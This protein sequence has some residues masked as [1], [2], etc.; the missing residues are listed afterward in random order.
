MYIYIEKISIAKKTA[1]VR[2][3]IGTR[4]RERR[5]KCIF[6]GTFSD[7]KDDDAAKTTELNQHKPAKLWFCSDIVWTDD[8]EETRNKTHHLLSGAFGLDKC[9]VVAIL[10]YFNF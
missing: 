8:K 4:E 5:T 3:M 10:Y 7:D 2:F 9:P 1:K 6:V